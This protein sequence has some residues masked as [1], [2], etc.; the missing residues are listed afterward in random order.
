MNGIWPQQNGT[1]DN[2]AYAP[3]APT[4]RSWRCPVC[5]RGYSSLVLECPHCQPDDMLNGT[6][7]HSTWGADMAQKSL[8]ELEMLLKVGRTDED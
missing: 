2:R 3:D 7:P 1:G 4:L 6:E 8:A 5:G